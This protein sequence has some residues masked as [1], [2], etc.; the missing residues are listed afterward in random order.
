MKRR[1]L[2]CLCLLATALS[3]Q[4]PAAGASAPPGD[5]GPRFFVT[6]PGAPSAASALRRAGLGEV[7]TIGSR[8]VT[9]TGDDARAGRALR[10]SAI[11]ARVSP[12]FTRRLSDVPNDSEYASQWNLNDAN[13]PNTG[14]RAEAAWSVTHGSA[15]I[16]V[17]D[18]DTGVDGT[19][20]DLAGKLVTGYDALHGTAL[21]A[22]NTDDGGHGTAVAGV[23]GAATNNGSVVAALGWDTKVMAIKAGDANGI[24]DSAAAAGLVYAADHGVRV[25]NMSFGGPDFS[26]GLAD[27]ATYAQARG[28]LLVAAVGN[29]ATTG[30]PVEY[31]AALPG[32]VGVGATGFDGTHAFYSNTGSQVD[33][34]A[35]GGSADGNPSHDIRVLQASGISTT[36][37][38]TSFASPTVAAAAALVLARNPVLQPAQTAQA[39]VNSTSDLGTPG[40]DPTFGAGLLDAAAA[41][42]LHAVVRRGGAWYVRNTLSTGVADTSFSYGNATD[43]GLLC[44]WDGNGSKTVGVFRGGTWYLRNSAGGGAGEISFAYGNPGDVP[45]CGDWNGNG[46]ETPGVYRRGVFYLRSS[47]TTGVA[48]LVV[49]FGDPGDVPIAGRWKPGGPATVGVYR[50]TSSTFYLRNQ[51]TVG[52]ADETEPFGNPGD[53]PLAGDWNGD[54]IDTVGVFRP[55]NATFYLRTD[56]TP[57]SGAIT[58]PYGTRGDV[59]IVGDW[60]R[61]GHDAIGVVR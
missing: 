17:A 20:A 32:V 52:V 13:G 50:P 53:Q 35:P 46:T 31:P 38:G 2:A 47:L 16:V 59:P 18:I 12:D 36:M 56:H 60:A 22:G 48:D 45:V 24:F 57:A 39:L 6:T 44:D 1:R 27:A 11:A 42:T 9:F 4:V 29:Q 5:A 23:I 41:L 10:A 58:V 55:P 19:H 28:V 34:V 43:V 3:T 33:L 26:Q 49:P 25:V 21:A 15:S 37:A 40:S 14:V 61:Q 54:G 51:N 30:N 8:V 7:R